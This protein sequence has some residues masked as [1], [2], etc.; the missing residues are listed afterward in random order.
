MREAPHL[1]RDVA[2]AG[3]LQAHVFFSP[4]CPCVALLVSHGSC[5]ESPSLVARGSLAGPFQPWP[6][7]M[8]REGRGEGRSL[9]RGGER[10]LAPGAKWARSG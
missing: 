1:H 5:L 2:V 4:P 9:R 8:K 6:L 10:E 7:G 3:D